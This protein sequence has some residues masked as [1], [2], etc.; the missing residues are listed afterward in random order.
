MDRA[1]LVGEKI[2]LRPLDRD[3]L[4]N[5]YIQWVN[6]EEVSRFM[7][8]LN[9]PTT[10]EKLESY[11]ENIMKSNNDV[12]FAIIEKKTDKHIGN[13][14]ININWVDRLG[15]Y[16]RMIGDKGSRGKGYGT[17]VS[18][19]MIKYSFE[20]L[21]LHKVMI[22]VMESNIASIKSNEKVGMKIEAKL[23]DHSYRLGKWED[24]I[25]MSIFR[26]DYFKLKQKG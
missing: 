26:D 3:D 10:K 15:I 14:K 23:K 18:K 8:T 6:D 13:V 25:Y 11:F 12:F 24:V 16:G 5:D 2:Y 17:E 4:E 1:F 21:N 7:E 9:F 22:G 19:L 20:R